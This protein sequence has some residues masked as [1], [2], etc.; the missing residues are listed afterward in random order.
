MPLGHYTEWFHGLFKTTEFRFRGE[1]RHREK[2]VA[3]ALFRMLGL[4]R[5][6]FI[7]GAVS[8]GGGE[9]L[10]PSSKIFYLNG[11][12]ATNVAGA[13]WRMPE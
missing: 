12:N 13:F 3:D 10:A 4:G 1:T 9:R 8:H 5:F 2:N 7:D 6:R 11:Q